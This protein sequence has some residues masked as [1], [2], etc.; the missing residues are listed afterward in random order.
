MRSIDRADPIDRLVRVERMIEHYRLEMNHRLER[1]A[2]T[3]WR[4]IEARE[5]ILEFEK[6]VERVH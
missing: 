4:K 3:L 2:L 1:R 5:M 6:P